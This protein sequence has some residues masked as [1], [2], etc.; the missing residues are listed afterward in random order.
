MT[1][2]VG[3]RLIDIKTIKDETLY[4]VRTWQ[5][6]KENSGQ[7]NSQRFQGQKISV[8][9]ITHRIQVII[10]LFEIS[11]TKDLRPSHA[12]VTLNIYFPRVT[13]INNITHLSALAHLK[14]CR[15]GMRLNVEA[16]GIWTTV[17]VGGAKVGKVMRTLFCV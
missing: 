2:L 1:Y 3:L 17:A 5:I 7:Y 13:A 4:L 8:S 9:S 6:G 10:T 16:R 15:G 12:I 14:I 11:S